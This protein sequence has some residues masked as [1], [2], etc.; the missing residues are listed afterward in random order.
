ML[1]SNFTVAQDCP[2]G[3]QEHDD[4]CYFVNNWESNLNWHDAQS[5]CLNEGGQLASVH[6]ADEQ[7]FITQLVCPLQKIINIK[8]V[9][10][11]LKLTY[12]SSVLDI[13]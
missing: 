5:F 7:N 3:W 8:E 11:E 6:D 4:L 1:N 12:H 13:T 10:F 9:Q 2:N